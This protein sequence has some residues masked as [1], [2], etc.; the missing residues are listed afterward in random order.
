MLSAQLRTWMAQSSDLTDP[1]FCISDR[2]DI[3]GPVD[4]DLM[5]AAHERVEQ[6]AEALRLR[7]VSTEDGYRQYL[8]PVGDSPL[9]HVDVSAEPDPQAAADAWM[10]ADMERPADPARLCTTALLRTAADRFTLYRRVHHA[11]L[12][13]WSLAL[14]HNRTAAVYTALAEGRSP[15]E[16][17]LPGFRVLLESEE[18]YAGS[19]RYAADRDYWLARFEDRPEPAQLTGRWSTTAR[20]A[21]RRRAELGPDRVARL[22]STADRLGVSWSDLATGIAAAYVG[23]MTNAAEVVLGTPTPARLSPQVRGVPGMTTNGLPVRVPMTPGTSLA[24]FARQVSLELRRTQLHSRYPSAELARELGLL[25]TGRR[26]W[27]QVVNVM[28]FDYELDFAGSP[29][30]VRTISLAPADD[31]AMTFYRTSA[32]EDIE[33]IVDAHPELHGPRETEAHLERLLF[34]IDSV[35]AADPGTPVEELPLVGDT[36]RERLR[37][38]GSGPV[39]EIEDTTVHGLVEAWARRSPQAPAVEFEQQVLSFAQLNERAN[40]LAR[41]LLAQG[42]RPGQVV[43]FALPRSPE[44]HIAALGVLKA[45]AAFLPLDPSYPLARLSFMV[46]DAAPALVLLHSDTAA[47]AEELDAP[48][49]VL[50][51]GEVARALAQLP[52]DDLGA[53]ERGGAH[54]PGAPAYVIY[55]SGSTGV[56]K[57]VVVRHSGVVNL[58]AAMVDRLGSGPG[59]RTLQ[60]ASSSFD[61]FVGEMT[62]CVLNGGTAVCAPAERLAPGPELLRLV[63]EKQINDLVLP[64]SALEV[65]APEEWPAGTT[66]SV[67]GEASSP[68]V[69]ERWAPVCRLINGYGPTEATVSTAMSTRLSPS[70]A[71]APPIGRPL[72]NVR[73]YV[74]DAG[75]RRVPAGAVGELYVAGAGVTLGYLGREELTAERF[76]ED[77]FGAPGE[78]MYRTGDLVRWA[79]DGELTFVGRNDDQVKI[80]GFRI[81]L[82]EV[83]AALVRSPGVARAAATVREDQPGNRQLVA[84]VVPAPGAGLDPARLRTRL[85]AGLPAHFVPS[86]IVAVEDLPRTANG[87][88]DRKALPAPRPATTAQRRPPGTERERELAELFAG[89]L[90]IEPPGV[91]DS[92]FDLGGHSLSATR[93]LGRIRKLTGV[94]LTVRELFAAPTVA[95]LAKLV[96]DSLSTT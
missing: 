42:V 43:A 85:A 52:G 37:A 1:T 18:Q 94:E 33:L 76:V 90:G 16:G 56:P 68:T 10:R 93:L 58:T 77:P 84:Y 24:D 9:H 2:L 25:G 31:L 57:G 53:Q 4:P 96:D 55:T 89:I 62:Q 65:M 21:H 69:I 88:L 8:A 45:G 72:R 51:H 20:I 91:D 92:F 71:G 80:R 73:V 13:G 59:T 39:H 3:R 32:D 95:G 30:S 60:F 19:K 17:A 23:R 22:R 83:E 87:K 5:R 81:E 41:H 64:P 40:R 15:A 46:G 11:V 14:V 63:V 54:S 49:L 78:R 6:E 27:G 50:D 36:E 70:Q 35:T 75:L 26:L 67:V 86:L 79:G 44:L 74:L 28:T 48:C 12:D 82:G 61:A 29:A 7:L 34:F 38:W 47:L 66:V